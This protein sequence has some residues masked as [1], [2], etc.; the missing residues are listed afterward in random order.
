MTRAIKWRGAAVPS[1][2]GEGDEVSGSFSGSRRAQRGGCGLTAVLEH[3]NA[4]HELVIVGKVELDD[5]ERRPVREAQVVRR[6]L[7]GRQ[8]ARDELTRKGDCWARER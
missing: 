4:E 5:A 1:R 6:R 8:V 3:G 7:D 2:G